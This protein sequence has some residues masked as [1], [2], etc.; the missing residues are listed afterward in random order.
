MDCAVIGAGFTTEQP[1]T[2]PDH[3]PRRPS[4]LVENGALTMVAVVVMFGLP[5][6]FAGAMLDP[7]DLNIPGLVRYW[8]IMLVLL[9]FAAWPV[10]LTQLPL[11]TAGHSRLAAIFN[12]WFGGTTLAV[13]V[14]HWLAALLSYSPSGAQ[15]DSHRLIAYSPKI[16]IALGLFILSLLVS[17]GFWAVIAPIRPQVA[18][19]GALITGPVLFAL[20][21]CAGWLLLT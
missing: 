19:A 13:C 2:V 6:L 8:A 16:G 12:V 15:V 4:R 5:M 11:P 21:Y 10:L 17:C 7:Q 18:V 1:H 14:I 3:H 9:P 20:V